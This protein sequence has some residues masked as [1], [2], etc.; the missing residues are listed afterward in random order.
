MF[1]RD[2]IKGML[3]GGA[4]GDALGG[5]V[6]T[7]SPER[8]NEIH[9]GP[10]TKY[11][12]PIGH[13]WFKPEEFFP[14][15]TT[16]DTQL[17]I[18]TMQGFIDGHETATLQN[19][20]E[21]YL[22]AIAAAHV[23]AMKKAIGGWGK[24]TTEA[25]RRLA[26]GVHWRESGKTTEKNRGTGNGVPMKVSPFAA[27]LGSKIGLE[28][29]NEEKIYQFNQRVVE[30]SAMT[31][32]TQISAYAAV[33]HA[34][35][36]YF[37]LYYDCNFVIKDFIDLVAD[38]VPDYAKGITSE[39]KADFNYYTV[40]HLEP[41]EDDL[42]KRLLTLYNKDLKRLSM[43]Q[44]RS[45]YGG[46]SCYVYDSLP[47]AYAIFLRNLHSMNGIIEAA[48]AGGDNDTNAKIV[49]EL[50]GASEGLEFFLRPENIWAV[51]GLRDYD[52][53]IELANCF[54]DTFGIPN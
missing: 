47:F 15:M 49:G 18:A 3:V 7:W 27:W 44:L 33:V 17:T 25:V 23:E 45:E 37:C 51:A 24:S 52:K 41:S 48:N 46:G 11:V 31:H 12:A 36:V 50:L 35:A 4:I 26:N 2:K 29:E 30:F 5:P 9:G 22:D 8:I 1:T 13:K 28:W 54:C 14:G 34:Q 21:P 43:D 42:F 53:L 6:E 10:I 32:Y 16:D 38:L 20:F 40:A 19:Y 39:E